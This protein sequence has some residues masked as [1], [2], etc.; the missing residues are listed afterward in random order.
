LV[1]KIN[2]AKENSFAMIAVL[3][4]K[5]TAL[6]KSAR[7]PL[8]VQVIEKE[9]SLTKNA[10]FTYSESNQN[11]DTIDNTNAQASL[12]VHSPGPERLAP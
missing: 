7:M 1:S 10:S 12:P 5:M 11:S 8:Y 4:M 2:E 6:K 3:I 9:D